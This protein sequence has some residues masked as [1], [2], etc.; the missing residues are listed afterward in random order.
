[1][2]EIFPKLSSLALP[3]RAP[4][5]VNPEV[6]KQQRKHGSDCNA[7][8]SRSTRNVAVVLANR[9]SRSNRSQD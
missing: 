4:E 6:K 7:A 9:R 2:K 3:S 1:M 8:Q 5:R